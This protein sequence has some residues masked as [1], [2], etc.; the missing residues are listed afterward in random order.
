MKKREYCVLVLFILLFSVT[1]VSAGIYFSQPEA[2]YN[3]G[4]L[5]DMN[6][7]CGFNIDK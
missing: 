2:I 1:N 5:I 4:D 3:F 6:L 7:V